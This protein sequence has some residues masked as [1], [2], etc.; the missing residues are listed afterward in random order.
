SVAPF[1]P[2]RPTHD[3]SSPAAPTFGLK[4]GAHH[5]GP[6]ADPSVPGD[7]EP[8]L[9]ERIAVWAN[10]TYRLAD[11]GPAEAQTCMYTTTQDES[12]ILE[13]RGPLLIGSPRPPP[14]PPLPPP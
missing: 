13:R 7:P 10:D 9:I 11:R 1:K 12:F 8:E 6:E 2:D 14:P 3:M 4:V 5:A